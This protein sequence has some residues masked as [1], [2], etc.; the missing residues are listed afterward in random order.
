MSEQ[1]GDPS[2]LEEGEPVVNGIGIAGAEQAG[3]GHG[4]S[5]LAG[6]DFEQGGTAFA[7]V[8]PRVMVPAVE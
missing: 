3:A 6:R 2:V 8:R 7:D 4:I 5:R 1:A